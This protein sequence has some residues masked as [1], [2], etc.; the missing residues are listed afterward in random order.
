MTQTISQ[1][2]VKSAKELLAQLTAMQSDVDTGK[3]ISTV[4]DPRL[5]LQ[6]FVPAGVSLEW[7]IGA[8]HWQA[9]G[10]RPFVRNE[11]PFLINNDGLLSTLAAV[12][13]FTNCR[14]PDA[15]ERPVNV[16][17]YGAGSG[18][19]A[20]F[21]LD[22]FRELC[23]QQ[24]TSDYDR[25]TY[26]VTDASPQTVSDWV[27]RG[28]FTE[29]STRVV[30]AVCN[31]EQIETL[32]T[33]DGK[34]VSLSNL[35][36]AFCNYVLDVLPC[37][38]V[39]HNNDTIEEL[40]IRTYLTADTTL[41]TGH[42]PLS[43]NDILA[44]VQSNSSSAR[45]QLER[46]MVLFDYETR[47]MPVTRTIPYINEA[48]TWGGDAERIVLNHGALTL[49]E[50]TA[51]LLDDNG[52]ILIND[53]GATEKTEQAAHGVSQRFGTTSAIGINFPFLEHFAENRKLRVLAPP[54]DSQRSIHTRLITRRPLPSTEQIFHAR[55]A[56]ES[57]NA[58]DA[59]AQQARSA[60]TNGNHAEALDRYRGAIEQQPR[61]WR[62]LG[63]IAEFI[64]FEIKDASAALEL[65]QR[66][67]ALNPNLSTWL[68]NILGDAL[69]MLERHTDAHT[70]Y[71]EAQRIDPDD[72]RT[73]L[74]LSYTLLHRVDPAAALD[75]IAK[76]LARDKNGSYR[77][78]LLTKQQ[79]I[80]ATISTTTGREHER[81][82][83]RLS[84]LQTNSIKNGS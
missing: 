63:E 2:P 41:L 72:P 4:S 60:I 39:R 78:R 20:R 65:A 8:L 1:P 46:L 29:H 3:I 43:P 16:V 68:W 52:F 34:I 13:V 21:F 32:T 66:A 73:L 81:S 22:A 12:L 27:E 74:N 17:E 51:E 47:F 82:L 57:I 26:F 55:F 45:T 58:F 6:D 11:V 84:R 49:L 40:N 83:L 75:A 44:L 33:I 37:A 79:H 10:V 9:M 25:L 54:D 59:P 30:P 50:Q 69:W 15:D 36:A 5:L 48:V 77:E 76:G 19:F 62:L 67:V 80:L 18:L 28:L 42:T 56:A 61:N 53:Y 64:L 31:A 24:G 71:L 7:E 38:L 70:A 23:I 14:E 35:R